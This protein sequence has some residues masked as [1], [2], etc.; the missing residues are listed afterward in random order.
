MASDDFYCNWNGSETAGLFKDSARQR[1]QTITNSKWSQ[2]VCLTLKGVSVIAIRIKRKVNR[3]K[4]TFKL[5]LIKSYGVRDQILHPDGYYSL[6]KRRK[7][8][9]CHSPQ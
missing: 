2:G 1:S 4:K 3:G 9:L 8:T 7:I 6:A 5:P